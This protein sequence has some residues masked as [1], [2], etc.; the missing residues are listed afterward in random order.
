MKSYANVLVLTRKEEKC[1]DTDFFISLTFLGRT[2][3]DKLFFIFLNNIELH[4]DVLT[5]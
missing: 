3:R 2:S 1:I 4:L 5:I